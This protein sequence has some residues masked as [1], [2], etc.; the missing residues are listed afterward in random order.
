VRE[1]LN[2]AFDFEEM[3]RTVPSAPTTRRQLLLEH[4]LASSGLP[5]GRELEILQG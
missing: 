2:Y 1:A 5:E 3:N 4:E